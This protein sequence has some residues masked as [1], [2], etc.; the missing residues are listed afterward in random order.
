M[1]QVAFVAER[2]EA[3]FAV[4]VTSTVTLVTQE[5]VAALSL[6]LSLVVG[7]TRSVSVFSIEAVST[8]LKDL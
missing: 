4:F 2:E 3:A 8:A 7:K 6:S 5:L 1:S